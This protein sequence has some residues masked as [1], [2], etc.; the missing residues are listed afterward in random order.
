MSA[1]TKEHSSSSC[2]E[3]VFRIKKRLEKM[4]KANEID[5]KMSIDMLNTLKNLQI[6]LE[7]LKNTGIG[8]VLNNL[9]KNCNSEELGS[10]AKS[11]LKN[12][13]KLV[14]NETSTNTSTGGSP[15]SPNSN[16]NDSQ[17]SPAPNLTEHLNQKS[18]N[19]NNNSNSNNNT[20]KKQTSTGSDTA[21]RLRLAFTDTKDPIR[22]KCREMLAQALELP[23]VIENGCEL[24]EPVDL[25]ARIEE[26]IFNEFQNTEIKYK[27]RIRSRVANLKDAKN[28]KLRESVRLGIISAE[29]FAKMTPEEMA[30]DE[31]K[32]LRAK[33]TEEAIKDHQ[34]AR[35]EG[36]KS[37]LLK[38]GKCKKSN[39]AYNQMQ[40][41]SADEPMTTFAFCQECGHRWKFC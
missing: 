16:S 2:E 23:E 3:D 20:L 7:I 12:W 37:S 4:I 26:T 5:P 35:L 18:S 6:D 39:V 34:M 33:F 36:A 14:S 9:R 19:N 31:L 30:S 21:S 17:S 25:S 29:R 15:K 27:N 1:G 41:R 8:V 40:T 11:L 32:N 22:L 13:K 28:P 24:Y 10:L 38:C